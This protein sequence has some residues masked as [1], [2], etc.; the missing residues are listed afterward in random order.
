MWH[1]VPNRGGRITIVPKSAAGRYRPVAAAG[2]AT[3]PAR[4]V[5]A[6]N[7]EYVQVPVAH[8]PDGSSITG[9]VL[10][11]H[12]QRQRPQFQPLM[13]FS[14]PVPYK[15][16]SL[17]TSKATLTTHA[18]E[19][20]DGKIGKTATMAPGDWAWA[21]CSAGHPFPGT[22]D[23]DPDLPEERLR[24]RLLYQVVFTAKDPPV[25]G[26]GFAA[27]RDVGSFFRYAAKDDTGTPNPLAGGIKW[28]IS[29]GRF[30]VG[31][32]PAPVPASGLQPGRSQAA[33]SMT[34]PGRS[35][36]GGASA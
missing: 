13:S 17:D 35:S 14:N 31:K 16:A 8:N 36:P 22:P 12:L 30:P 25:L 21:K 32:F 26:I 11:A 20:I 28:T 34:A 18:S 7:N 33:R 10:G 29:R 2:R 6:P 5:R 1:D 24:S 4:T 15:P 3:I 9:P 23:P 27:F 19:T